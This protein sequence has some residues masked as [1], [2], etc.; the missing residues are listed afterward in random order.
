VPKAKPGHS[1]GAA[2]PGPVRAP[3]VCRDGLSSDAAEGRELS[4]LY[5]S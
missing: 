4:N 1:Q 5:K 2:S 3:G